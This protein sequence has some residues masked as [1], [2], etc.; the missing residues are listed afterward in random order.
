[1]L[2]F[3]AKVGVLAFFPSSPLTAAAAAANVRAMAVAAIAAA[4]TST[5]FYLITSCI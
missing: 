5:S 3:S 2:I 4:S 1:M